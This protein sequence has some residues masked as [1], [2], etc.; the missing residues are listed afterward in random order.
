MTDIYQTITNKIVAAIEAG[1]G[2][3]RMP[4]HRRGN[5]STQPVNLD[6]KRY[7]GSNV[8]SLWCAAQ[9][10]GYDLPIWGTYQRWQEAGGQVRRGE[11]STLIVFWKSS[12]KTVVNDAGE[13]QV[14]KHLFARGYNVFNVAQVDG[15]E[16][17]PLD[18]PPVCDRIA[19]AERF[20]ASFPV[21]VAHGGD[22]AFYVPSQDRIQLPEF[23]RFV[24]AESYYATMAHEC[25]H[26][27][28]HKS[29]LDRDLSGRFGSESY[30]IEEL[31][32]ELTAA[33]VAGHLN[34]A[35]EP[36]PDHAQYLASW[37]RVL[38]QDARAIFTVSSR[39]QAAADWIIDHSGE[40]S[41]EESDLDFAIAA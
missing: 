28:G 35:N 29:R 8:V 25:G 24:D 6:G 39:A 14:E 7:R 18:L 30:G 22:R 4:W 2:D 38:K 16:L 31:I 10:A 37:L 40:K 19:R 36:R 27:T 5:G 17:P 41:A 11:K 33:F 21:P 3:W 32:A 20:F 1:A 13:E 34:L 9:A 26:A 12:E 23:S 15:Y